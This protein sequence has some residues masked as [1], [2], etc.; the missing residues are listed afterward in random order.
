MEIRYQRV[1]DMPL[2]AGINVNLRPAAAGF[3]FSRGARRFQRA[4]RC[5]PH[6]NDPATFRLRPVD[7]SRGFLGH[8]VEFPVHG[9]VFYVFLRNRPES[10]QPYIKG[11]K[12]FLTSHVLYFLQQFFRKVQPCSGRC[13]GTGIPVIYGLVPFLIFQFCR[14]IWR[15]RNLSQPV[16][17]FFKY[18]LKR[19][20]DDAPAKIRMIDDRSG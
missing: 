7:G 15:Q 8:A 18:A 20:T 13:R 1:H 3:Y 5:R 16:Q 12:H 19:K 14:N 6:R 11:D 17:Y 2:E 4:H 10:S 9:M